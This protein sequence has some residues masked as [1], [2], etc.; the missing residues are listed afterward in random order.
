MVVLSDDRC[1]HKYVSDGFRFDANSQICAGE[2]GLN[3]GAC[4][5]DSGGPFVRQMEDGRW[6]V[7][8]LISW[9]NDCGIGTVFTRV[10]YFLPWI[11]NI[12]ATN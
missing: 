2:P 6:Y 1:V 12:I 8:G 9:G 4:Q 7:I 3:S 5:G 11:K 10:T